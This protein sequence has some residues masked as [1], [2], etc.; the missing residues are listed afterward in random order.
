MSLSSIM[1]GRSQSSSYLALGLGGVGFLL[2]LDDDVVVLGMG[3]GGRTGLLF[4]ALLWSSCEGSGG[5]RVT[6]SN[7]N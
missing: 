4:K 7:E 1:P 3:G 5:G 2:S 6:A